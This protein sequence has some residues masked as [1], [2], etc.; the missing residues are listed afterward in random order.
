MLK[1]DQN[2][3]RERLAILGIA[4]MIAAA[5]YGWLI[6]GIVDN[7]DDMQAGDAIRQQ[8]IVECHNDGGI[9]LRDATDRERLFCLGVD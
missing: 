2:R 9:I 3:G 8:I 1:S 5:F 4:I 6:K 7:W